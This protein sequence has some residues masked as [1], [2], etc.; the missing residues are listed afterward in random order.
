ME[1]ESPDTV[2]DATFRT[3]EMC[4]ECTEIKQLL[5]SPCTLGDPYRCHD[6]I[7]PILLVLTLS[8][9]AYSG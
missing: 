3:E 2:L 5:L 1:Q 4:K 9:W 6:D 8:P 7:L